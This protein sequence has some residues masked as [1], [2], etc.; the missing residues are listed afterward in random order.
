MEN[1]ETQELQTPAQNPEQDALVAAALQQLA[2]TSL[3]RAAGSDDTIIIG[4]DRK[5]VEFIRT[6]AAR[7]ALKDAGN[8]VEYWVGEVVR[9][10]LKTLKLR[11]EQAIDRNVEKGF[12]ADMKA[13]SN[14]NLKPEIRARVEIQ[15]RAKWG[16][17]GTEAQA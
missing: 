11:H 6:L 13:L 17:G 16:I 15:I 8:T 10:G 1:S 2:G 3:G 4:V 7:A 5:S 14:M 12:T 9:T